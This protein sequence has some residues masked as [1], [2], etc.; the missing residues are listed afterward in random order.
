MMND[1]NDLENLWNKLLSR[2]AARV[3]EAFARLEIEEQQAVLKHLERMSVEEGWHPE[4]RTSA[5]AA[6]AALTSFQ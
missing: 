3:Q 6:L 4:Q 5:R 2:D 1:D